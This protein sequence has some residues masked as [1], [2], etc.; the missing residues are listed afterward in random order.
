MKDKTLLAVLFIA[1]ILLP[2]SM[3]CYR[4]PAEDAGPVEIGQPAPQFTLRDLDGKTVSLDQ[5]K[6]KIVILDFWA[7]W[8]GPCRMSMPMLDA[9]QDQYKGK[10]VLLAVN[11]N[12]PK[13]IV[14]DYVVNGNLGSRVLLDEDGSIGG[15]YGV[16]GIPTQVVIDQNGTVQF[17][18]SGFDPGLEAGPGREAR[19]G[20]EDRI[21]AEINK[22]L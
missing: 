11:V 8:C 3:Q 21:R 12:E 10:L 16:I 18:E 22:L 4:P 9:I 13:D 14:R 2:L 1:I 20:T 17:I 7:T 5:Y 19:P 15:L 6:G